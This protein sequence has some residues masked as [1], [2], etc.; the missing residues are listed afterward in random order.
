VGQRVEARD[1]TGVF[2]EAFIE[3]VRV[4]DGVQVSVNDN[5][6]LFMQSGLLTV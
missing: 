6:V 5:F 4:R 1:T 2:L 3:D